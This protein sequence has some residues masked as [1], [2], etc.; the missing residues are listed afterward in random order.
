MAKRLRKD[1]DNN[2]THLKTL[3]EEESR[4]PI[5][6]RETITKALDERGGVHGSV[7]DHEGQGLV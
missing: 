3:N 4:G 1:F 6:D 5:T 7:P 2:P